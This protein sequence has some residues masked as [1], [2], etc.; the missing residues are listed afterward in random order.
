[1][2]FGLASAIAVVAAPAAGSAAKAPAIRMSA[3]AQPTPDVSS[4]WAG[5]V[6]T[7]QPSAGGVVATPAATFTDVA[8]TWV[9]SK[10]TCDTGELASSAF[11]VGLG[12]V[13]ENS[14]GL[15]QLGTEADCTPSGK[16]SYS[17]WY[18][19]LP[20]DPVELKMRI[21]PGDRIS[22]AVLSVGQQVVL[23]MKNLTRHTRF[24]K[25][26]PFVDPLDLG[27]AEWI[28]EAPSACSADGRRCRIVPLTNFGKV[29]FT[30]AA[31]IGS[32]H[33][34]TISDPSWSAE[35][36]SLVPDTSSQTNVGG[37]AN[38]HGASPSNL[39]IDGRS[40]S[41]AWQRTPT[42]TSNP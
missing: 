24:S 17:A 31:A 34:G 6:V 25:R 20:A 32:S 5:Y 33:P 21:R 18:E 15:E 10:A 4:N 7:A 22:A 36:V 39:S 1:V 40:F 11:W 27:S 28:A 9:Q 3:L 29:T 41:V 42:A 37:A 13:D 2:A 16:V 35:Q 30:G 19:L 23:S 8:G 26:L 14:Q 12:G 38:T